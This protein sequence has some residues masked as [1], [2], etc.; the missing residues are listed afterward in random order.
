MFD[1]WLQKVLVWRNYLCFKISHNKDFC[2]LLFT[3]GL[4]T[5]IS[6]IVWNCDQMSTS[7]QSGKRDPIAGGFPFP[8]NQDSGAQLPRFTKLTESNTT[9][10]KITNLFCCGYFDSTK[11]VLTVPGAVS[12]TGNSLISFSLLIPG[13]GEETQAVTMR[14]RKLQAAKTTNK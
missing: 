9:L 6:K 14:A 4:N 2:D 8:Q 3:N 5:V 12:Q 11:L 13:G 1:I 10:R 7:F